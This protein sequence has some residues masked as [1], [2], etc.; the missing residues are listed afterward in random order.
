MQRRRAAVFYTFVL[1]FA[2]PLLGAGGLASIKP[3]DL[4]TWL[5]YIASDELRGRQ[6]YSEGL[7]LAA[8]YIQAHLETWGVKPA[9]DRGG[10]LQTVRVL[11]VKT[12]SRSSLT[13]QVGG[14]SRTFKDGEGV[15]FPRNAGAKQTVTAD[16][17]EFIGYGLDAPAV[18][19]FDLR[20]K[21]LRGANFKGAKLAGLDLEVRPRRRMKL[22]IPELPDIPADS[23]MTIDEETVAHWRPALRGAYALFTDPSTPV[24]EPTDNVTPDARFAFDLL[25]PTSPRAMARI[26]PF[27]K[28]VWARG[29]PDW[30][31]QA[32]QYEYTP[33]HRPFVSPTPVDGL[34]LNG[35]WSGH[36]VMGS[37]GGS[38]L[39]LDAIQGTSSGPAWG[40]RLDGP[41]GNPFRLDRTF[42]ELRHD[43]L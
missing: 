18:N 19:H 25:T 38:R 30:V 10:Y 9:G 2:A 28:D 37:G 11:G 5:T 29:E 43:V 31:L 24:T 7:G 8:G 42:P 34:W 23:P 6:I 20:G 33:D 32:G 26:S 13:A 12:T 41:A 4:K 39:L 14:E 15:T 21:D 16:R 36:G 17:V 3:A 22:V 27:W 40:L 1:V 35:G